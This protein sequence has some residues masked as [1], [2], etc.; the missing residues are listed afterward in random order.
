MG[1]LAE[2]GSV[3]SCLMGIRIILTESP[4]TS[5]AQNRPDLCWNEASVYIV[6]LGAA[7]SS[8]FVV[9]VRGKLTNSFTERR[10]VASFSEKTRGTSSGRLM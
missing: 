1:C 4:A 2:A 10:Q 5:T 6:T 7:R 3:C 9:F 8:S